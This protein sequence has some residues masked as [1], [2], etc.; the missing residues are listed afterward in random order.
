MEQQVLSEER[1][2]SLNM[3]KSDLEE[4]VKNYSKQYRII[5]NGSFKITD[6]EQLFLIQEFNRVFTKKDFNSRN[7]ALFKQVKTKLEEHGVI[8]KTE[9]DLTELKLKNA[10]SLLAYK[11][12]LEE[13]Q[14]EEEEEKKKNTEQNT[15]KEE[16]N[17]KK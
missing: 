2:F 16:Q 17:T 11:K 7:Y 13:E 9:Q 1:L 4:E 3:Y 12:Q 5:K 6:E 8:F 10:K 14:Q 15:K